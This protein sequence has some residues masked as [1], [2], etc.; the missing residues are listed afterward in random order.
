[1]VN[2]ANFVF[3]IFLAF[4]GIIIPILIIGIYSTASAVEK[5]KDE[6]K[7]KQSENDIRINRKIE[8]L[9]NQ[10]R[11]FTQKE[12]IKDSNRVSKEIRKLQKTREKFNRRSSML[13]K[14]YELLNYKDG[15]VLPYLFVFFAIIFAVLGVKSD[16][17]AAIFTSYFF[18]FLFLLIGSF[19]IFKCLIIIRNVKAKSKEYEK[20][21]ISDAFHRAFDKPEKKDKS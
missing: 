13:L 5:S 21:S 17:P 4:L 12:L 1:M 6:I 9:D 11:E 8:E 10:N 16:S 18:V 7:R 15:V 14:R 2:L 3:F 20:E 19:R